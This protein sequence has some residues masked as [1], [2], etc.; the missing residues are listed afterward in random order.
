MNKNVYS[1]FTPVN[2]VDASTVNPCSFFDRI[3]F[4]KCSFFYHELSCF[5]PM[6]GTDKKDGCVL[7]HRENLNLVVSP[8]FTQKT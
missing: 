6:L 8:Q 1:K 2:P 4:C 7:T 5:C 3:A